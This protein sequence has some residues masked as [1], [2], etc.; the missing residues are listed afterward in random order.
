MNSIKHNRK[1]RYDMAEK[2]KR[3]G[4]I[5]VMAGL[6]VTGIYNYVKGN[7]IFNKSRFKDQHDAVSRYVEAHYPGA[8]YSPIQATE[9]GWLTIITTQ[10]NKNISLTI[11]KCDDNIFVF[12][13]ETV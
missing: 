13:E 4:L 12:K 3:Y 1:G 2:K 9:N 11:T 10:D 6:A 5:T 7:G 8:F